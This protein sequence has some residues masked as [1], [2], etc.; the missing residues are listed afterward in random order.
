MEQLFAEREAQLAQTLEKIKAIDEKNAQL[1]ELIEKKRLQQS[2]G[3][4]DD[5]S[6]TSPCLEDC[7]K[8]E[9]HEDRNI[10]WFLRELIERKRHY[11]KEDEKQEEILEARDPGVPLNGA[12]G[13]RAT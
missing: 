5:D 13:A 9:Y 3:A 12:I 11:Q 10:D 4:D 6:A 8:V 7:E 2:A 1:S